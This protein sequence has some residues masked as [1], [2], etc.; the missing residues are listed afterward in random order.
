MP[1]NTPR[2]SAERLGM[3]TLVQ[4]GQRRTYTSIRMIGY[5]IDRSSLALS[6]SARTVTD[7]H[8]ILR[9]NV[10]ALVCCDE[11]SA[12]HAAQQTTGFDALRQRRSSCATALSLMPRSGRC[13]SPL[14]VIDVGIQ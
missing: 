11:R 6:L 5:Q 3:P 10:T 7:G 8:V 4:P 14:L 9:R 2:T 1:I 13:S 12:A